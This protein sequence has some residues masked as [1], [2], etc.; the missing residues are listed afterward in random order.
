MEAFQKHPHGAL[1]AEYLTLIGIPEPSQRL[2]NDIL[3]SSTPELQ[4][5][6]FAFADN[7]WKRAFKTANR[8]KLH[9]DVDNIRAL[10]RRL[11]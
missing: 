1:I 11:G 4:R 9:E 5:K 6:M 2:V 7:L 10:A 3:S 8:E